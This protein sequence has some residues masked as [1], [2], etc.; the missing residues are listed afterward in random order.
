M[1]QAAPKDGKMSHTRSH[2][3]GHTH[4]PHKPIK[5]KKKKKEIYM[6][7]HTHIPYLSLTQW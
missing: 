7:S 5:R 6:I 1:I 3:T 2:L 4:L